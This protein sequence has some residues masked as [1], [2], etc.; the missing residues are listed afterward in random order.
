LCP[1]FVSPLLSVVKL[2]T[3]IFP[4]VDELLNI[5]NYFFSNVER[6]LQPKI[7]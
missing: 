6:P 5:G 3:A 2:I 7:A 4:M 1:F